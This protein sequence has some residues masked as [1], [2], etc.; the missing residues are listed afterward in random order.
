MPHFP[1]P[2]A[3]LR[4]LTLIV[5]E[6][7]SA[8]GTV[9]LGGFN[10]ERATHMVENAISRRFRKRK[11][12][13]CYRKRGQLKCVLSNLIGNDCLQTPNLP[14]TK[15][16]CV[17]RTHSYVRC[18]QQNDDHSRSRQTA[19]MNASQEI[20]LGQDTGTN[21]AHLLLLSGPRVLEQN[22]FSISSV[23]DVFA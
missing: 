3:L 1:Q 21:S 13:I 2:F 15:V 5:W 8:A 14:A 20:A 7:E 17:S 4:H 9:I 16:L 18:H 10:G 22:N 23:V 19:H 11:Q 12:V 6:R